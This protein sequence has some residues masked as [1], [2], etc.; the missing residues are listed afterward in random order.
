[1]KYVYVIWDPLRERVNCAHEEENNHGE[2]HLDH[3]KPVSWANDEE[4]LLSLNYYTNFQPKW[5]FD[6]LSKGNRYEG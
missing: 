3:I 1:M 6:N 2:W 5:S 4:E